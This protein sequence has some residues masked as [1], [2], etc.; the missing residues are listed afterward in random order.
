MN[1]IKSFNDRAEALNNEIIAAIK[2]DSKI[3]EGEA[4]EFGQGISWQDSNGE[5]QWASGILLSDG[6]LRAVFQAKP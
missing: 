6:E 5:T 1:S 2:M 3:K 4:I